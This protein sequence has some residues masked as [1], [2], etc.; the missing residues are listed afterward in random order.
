MNHRL[1]V[2]LELVLSNQGGDEIPVCF[3]LEKIRKLPGCAEVSESEL[4][5]LLDELTEQGLYEA[6]L[7]DDGGLTGSSLIWKSE[8]HPSIADFDQNPILL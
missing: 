6:M 1:L 3:V 2:S 5:S 7:A 4:I 8:S